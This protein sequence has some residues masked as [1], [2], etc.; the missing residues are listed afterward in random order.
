MKKL[1]MISIL[2]AIISIQGYAQKT[3]EVI[4]HSETSLIQTKDDNTKLVNFEFS[5]FVNEKQIQ[6]TEQF[7]RGYRG[8]IDFK[9][10]KDSNTNKYI[11]TGQFYEYANNQYFSSLLGRAGLEYVKIDNETMPIENLKNL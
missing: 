1:L 2:A 9:I 8:V 10:E 11:G 3:V 4:R 7:I 6:V 5:G